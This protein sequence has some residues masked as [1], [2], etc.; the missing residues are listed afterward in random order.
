MKQILTISS[1]LFLLLFFVPSHVAAIPGGGGSGTGNCYPMGGNYAPP[2]TGMWCNCTESPDCSGSYIGCGGMFDSYSSYCQTGGSGSTGG[3]GGG[4][5]ACRALNQSCNSPSG[6]Q[7]NCCNGKVCVSP[8]G[9]SNVCKNG[10]CAPT[11]KTGSDYADGCCSGTSPD[12]KGACQC[13]TPSNPYSLSPNNTAVCPGTSNLTWQPAGKN[14]RFT[15]DDSGTAATS[16]DVCNNPAGKNHAGEECGYLTTNSWSYNTTAGRSYGWTV[17]S[18]NTLSGCNQPSGKASGNFTA[19][20]Q[21]NIPTNLKPTGTTTPGTKNITWSAPSNSDSNT[22]YQITVDDSGSSSVS[23]TATTGQAGSNHAGDECYT[24]ASGTSW[25]YTFVSGHTY[26]I[27]IRS[28]SSCSSLPGLSGALSGTAT[29]PNAY[30]TVAVQGKL[31]EYSTLVCTDNISTSALSLTMTAQNSTGV[32]TNCG[33]TPAVGTTSGTLASYRCTAT[34]D[35]FANPTPAQ[36]MTIAASSS[37][38]QP[39]A[40]V[41]AN[42][43]SATGVNT[44]AVNVAASTPVNVFNKD[45][46]FKSVG[47][48]VKILNGAFATANNT[49]NVVSTSIAPYDSQDD[50]TRNFIISSAGSDPGSALAPTLNLGTGSVSSKGWLATGYTKA[51]T[52]SPSVFLEYVKARKEFVNIDQSDLS[53]LQDGK[54][55]IW[56]GGDLTINSSNASK[57]NGKRAVLVTNGAVNITE[58]FTPSSASAAIIADTITFT[59]DPSPVT[60]ANGLFVA[61]TVSTGLTDNQGL[62]ITGNL[63]AGTL[64][65]DRY[66]VG[67][68]KPTVFVVLDPSLFI[69]LLPWASVSKY[70]YRQTQ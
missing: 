55:N 42:V 18:V 41:D 62:K 64:N 20:S 46:L 31:R 34:F 69:N 9:K 67:N 1:F 68:T 11:G 7:E 49:S 51:S 26:D 39:G 32:T 2:L 12:G 56:T 57:F 35:V 27:S 17:Q 8:D 36:N 10:G 63:V 47:P 4:A 6:K 33:I 16:G 30:P 3:G 28:K 15:V 19:S 29:V 21:P 43:C 54:I 61:N 40:L 50:G 25:S 23:C 66:W 14:Y 24:N 44:V 70:E 52:L 13:T 48:W 59:G 5:P 37:D 38:Y 53:E 65:N 45:L 60:Q 22:R 58:N